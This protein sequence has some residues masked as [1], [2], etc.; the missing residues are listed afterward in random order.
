VPAEE[1]KDI[2]AAMTMVGGRVVY[3]LSSP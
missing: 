1:I 2:R 3:S